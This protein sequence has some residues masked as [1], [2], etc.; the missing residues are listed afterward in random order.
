MVV[1]HYQSNTMAPV[2]VY[3]SLNFCCEIPQFSE[4]ISIFK[5]RIG[6][7]MIVCFLSKYKIVHLAVI[8]CE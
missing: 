8:V 4:T 1:H 6:G 3:L 5:T 7:V 2:Y